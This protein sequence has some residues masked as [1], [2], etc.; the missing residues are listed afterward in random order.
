MRNNMA[1]AYTPG[2]QVTERT[3]IR[4]ERTLPL[5]GE[6]LV[7]MGEVVTADSV[8]AKTDLPGD[9]VSVNVV[10]QLGITASEIG[11]YM[12]KKE[13][14]AVEEREPLAQSKPFIKWFQSTI[15]SPI[16]GTVESVSDVTGQVLLRKPPKPIELSAY[17]DGRVV[18]VTEGGGAVIEAT[19][20]F[21]QG[22]FGIG[23]E[24]AGELLL[25]A[26]AADSVLSA[27][28]IRDEHREKILIGGALVEGSAL[29]RAEEVGV[30]GIIVGGFRAGDL[31]EW[32]GYEVGVAVTGDEDVKTTLILTEGFGKMGM[33]RRTFDL[34][35]SRSGERASVSGRTQIRAGVMRP[36]VIIPS[37][38]GERSV[39]EH[40]TKIS[41]V[42]IGDEV[43]IIREPY[44]G[45]LGKVKA[46]PG[47]LAE[48][49]TEAKVR[50]MEVGLDGGDVVTVPRANVELIE[51]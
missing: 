7:K 1:H 51:E 11:E 43:R 39:A 31:R 23:K 5:P 50:V 42:D 13:G 49:E 25:V 32:L 33:A 14:D 41:G 15:N 34:L 22:I 19:A 46:L 47:E 48:I 40:E 26:D 30:A 4:K 29:K 8:I 28:D 6:V 9:V 20:S 37:P 44:F 45:K 21:V 36:E 38:E 2:L 35:S 10:N 17:I 3:V 18:E 27:T 12:L 24:R 16:T